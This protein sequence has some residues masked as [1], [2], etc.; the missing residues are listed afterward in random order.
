MV[1]PRPPLRSFPD[2]LWGAALFYRV[3]TRAGP[4]TRIRPRSAEYGP[5][6]M[7]G[8]GHRRIMRHRGGLP[9]S[10]DGGI[11]RSLTPLDGRIDLEQDL[12]HQGKIPPRIER[13]EFDA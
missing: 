7:L 11:G 6:P 12:V 13:E 2:W 1:S 8:H 4:A 10:I 5:A 3:H 9:A